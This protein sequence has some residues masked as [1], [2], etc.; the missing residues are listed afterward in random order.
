MST[1]KKTED[2]EAKPSIVGLN[3]KVLKK[4]GEGSFGVIYEGKHS[5]SKKSFYFFLWP[6]L[7]GTFVRLFAASWL[8]KAP[9]GTLSAVAANQPT[10]R[11]G[12]FRNAYFGETT[13]CN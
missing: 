7:V 3:Y 10:N 11:R 13:C 4:I 9:R 6:G 5:A 12:L 8:H 1:L 2:I